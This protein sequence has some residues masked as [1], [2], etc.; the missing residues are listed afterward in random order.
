MLSVKRHLVIDSSRFSRRA[1]FEITHRLRLEQWISLLLV[2]AALQAGSV[3][4][5]MSEPC[6][7]F[8]YES[9]ANRVKTI[10][11][12]IVMTLSEGVINLALMFI[13]GYVMRC[14]FALWKDQMSYNDASLKMIFLLTVLTSATPLAFKTI[15]TTYDM[16]VSFAWP[17]FKA[18]VPLWISM[19]DISSSVSD[20]KR[21]ISNYD[22][23]FPRNSMLEMIHLY[24]FLI[25]LRHA[26]VII[27]IYTIVGTFALMVSSGLVL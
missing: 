3:S 18:L 13:A 24:K 22:L 11:A 27:I 25:V 15:D 10:V 26:K 21:S 9:K 14:E 6:P 19:R 17:L 2:F 16:S 1:Y 4:L 12:I 8:F 23:D 7:Y 5:L 20:I